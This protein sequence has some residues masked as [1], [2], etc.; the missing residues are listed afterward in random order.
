MPPGKSKTKS[1]QSLVEGLSYEQALAE[2]ENIVASL[3]ANKLSVEDAMAPFER[4][5]TLTIHWVGML[6]KAELRI[7][8]L[9]G[10]SLVDVIIEE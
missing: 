8:E 4:G 7:K 5:Q 6:D 9:S 3:E 1:N 10:D 2:L